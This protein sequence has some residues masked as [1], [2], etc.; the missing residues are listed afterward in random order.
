[1][2][3]RILAPPATHRIIADAGTASSVAD[4]PAQQPRPLVVVLAGQSNMAG[5]GVT[6]ELTPE[7]TRMPR[8]VRYV[9]AG[10]DATFAGQSAFGPE[11]AIAHELARALPDRQIVIIK[12]AV[13]GTSLLA[14][15]PAWDSVRAVQTDNATAGPLYRHLRDAIAGARLPASAEI[16]AV[17]WMQGE[18]DARYTEAGRDYLA[19]LRELVAALRRDLNSPLLPFVLGLVNPPDDSYS[20][21][22]EVRAAQRR[23]AAEIASVYL[24]ETDDLS[25]RNDRLHYDTRGLL[26][27]GRRFAAVVISLGSVPVR[28]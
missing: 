13:G 22:S 1:M 28:R 17:L 14:W 15:A 24:V 27:L 7:Q 21:Q 4:A 11:V 16:A 10:Q 12:Y 9:H 20:A 2:G 25:K 5:L 26:E 3:I 18:R 6:R 19:N 8:N 23:A